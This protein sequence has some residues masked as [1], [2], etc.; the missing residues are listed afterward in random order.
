MGPRGTLACGGGG[1]GRWLHGVVRDNTT[2][3]QIHKRS[4]VQFAIL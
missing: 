2:T 4:A 1:N 3:G